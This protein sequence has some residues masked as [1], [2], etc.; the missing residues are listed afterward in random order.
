MNMFANSLRHM[1]AIPA[2]GKW[3]EDQ[4]FKVILSLRSDWIEAIAQ[5]FKPSARHL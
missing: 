3:E 1:P 4:G 2:V 5:W